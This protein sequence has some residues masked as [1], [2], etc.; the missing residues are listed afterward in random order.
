MNKS[1]EPQAV[2]NRLIKSLREKG[3]K[4]TQQRLEIIRLLSKDT[5]HPG[6]MDILK[7]VR[8]KAPRVSCKKC[9][10]IED[11]PENLPFSSDTVE[12]KTGFQPVSM[13]FE[14]YGYC[15]ECRPKKK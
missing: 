5:T 8:K 15:K 2:E 12:G 6:A 4:L 11:F 10:T 1:A 3:Y 13:R 14:Y 7:Q 9:G